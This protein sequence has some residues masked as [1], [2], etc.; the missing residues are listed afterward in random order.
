MKGIR[1]RSIS[2][3]PKMENLKQINTNACGI[4]IG[5]TE[6]YICIPED[7]DEQSVRKFGT[8]T[9]DLKAI[10]R[11][12]QKCSIDTVAME[13]TGIY[14]IPL[15]ETLVAKGFKVSL[16]NARSVKNVPG[17]KTDILDCQWIQQ[18]HTYGLLSDSFHPD[19]DINSYS[20]QR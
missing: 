1:K 11:W 2:K 20:A 17:R 16:V 7:R 9:S 4:D 6:I 12:L 18:L 10:A 8:F 15:Y 13:S 5:S 14:W 3:A 19:E